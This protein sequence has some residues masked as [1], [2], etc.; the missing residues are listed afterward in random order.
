MKR[1]G[2][3]SEG[4]TD[5][6]GL[7]GALLLRIA[8]FARPHW[9]PLV[10]S[11]VLMPIFSAMQ[12]VQPYLIK[13]AIDGPISEGDPSGLLPI[14]GLLLT[15]MIASYTLQFISSYA[16]HLGGQAIVHDL[17][18]AVHRHL[19]SLRASY[20]QKHPAGR[21]LTRCTNDVEGIGE[22]F[23]AGFL[24][25]FGDLIMLV[26][27]CV[28]LVL[29]N[30]QLALFTFATLPI[31]LGVSQWFQLNLRQT[32]R[33]LRRRVA[34]INA[35]LQER[36]SG[37]R[38]IQL[39]NREERSFAEF[40]DRNDEL[41]AENFRSIRLDAALFAF[42]DGMAH[43][44]TA[45]LVWWA[46]APIVEEAL[47]F[48]ALVAFLDYVGRFFQPIRDLSQK[49]AVLQSGLASSERV[50]DL[51]DETEQVKG[52][53]GSEGAGEPTAE[54]G[55]S[56][57]FAGVHF[58]YLPTEPV[59]KG[60][61]LSIRAGEKI[62]LLGVTGAGK[63]TALRLINRGYDAVSGTVSIDGTD[64]LDWPVAALRQRVGVVL[65]DVFLFG[66]SVRE[67]VGLGV[68]DL[69]D[70]VL[71]DALRQVGADGV[72]ERIGGLDA[73]IG[74]RGGRLSAGERQLLSFARVLVYDPGIL[75]LDEATSNVDT[76]AEERI[77]RA[78]E[79]TMEGRTTVVVAHRLS[80]IQQ[81]DR[82]AVLRGGQLAEL[83]TH[84]ELLAT[85][86]IYKKLYE[87]YFAPA[88]LIEAG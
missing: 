16:S 6:A 66:G 57:E 47:T 86:G 62:A 38:V 23:A 40:D 76:F 69:G 27:I 82:I 34:V 52:P 30:W 2:A 12:L 45:G 75:L 24:T 68:V 87:N 84:R 64:V 49:V 50:F 10:G 36:I 37:I 79:K 13:Q 70:D 73:P 51:L 33:A 29:L 85:D 77:Q 7:D 59:L 32:Y 54:R 41:M 25:L 67:N 35:Y 56:I 48:G 17:R 60:L 20:F 71:W 1:P 39:F 43:L 78:I 72:V 14:A 19:V 8:R 22:M 18:S 74:E 15:V 42:V 9:R 83:G 63:S 58:A 80:T 61:D 81:V 65:Q 46:A 44:V 31:L 55:G 4:E 21:L 53:P 26:G 88:A 11:L 28:A 5:W 3:R